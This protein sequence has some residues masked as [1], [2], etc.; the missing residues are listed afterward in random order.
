MGI[1]A[2]ADDTTG[3]LE[4]GAQ[5]ARS[6]V[7]AWISL[8]PVPLPFDTTGLVLDLFV[9]HL[10]ADLA[11]DR[12]R[13][14]AVQARDAGIPYLYLKTDS[15]LRGP[16]G[17]EFQALLE[18][19][20]DRAL[21]YAPAYPA[22]GRTVI[23]GVLYVDGQPLAETAFA[24]D[25]LEPAR[26]SSVLRL[27]QREC[28]APVQLVRTPEEL[29]TALAQRQGG[30]VL[31][32]DGR[33]DADLRAFAQVLTAHPDPYLV[34][35]PAGFVG[36]WTPL[37]PV[38]RNYVPPRLRA[39]RWLV[40]NG[41]LHPRSREQTA[42]SDL[43]RV[44]PGQGMPEDGNWALLETPAEACG[45]APDIARRLA[46]TA[47]RLVMQSGIEGLVVFGG[48][49]AR[50]ILEALHVRRVEACGELLP[51]IPVS[52]A[53]SS[54]LILVSKAGGFGPPDVLARIRQEAERWQ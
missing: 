51:G 30:R 43:P 13:D 19:Y 4:V 34:A 1:L 37:L 28:K 22:L 40:I 46:E 54:G 39:R 38:P 17:A 52:R 53:P 47:A 11:A 27:V 7:C 48:D 25:P 9:R 49:T 24:R 41:S 2:L 6:G 15:T 20:P 3:A 18:T 44:L 45:A 12:V 8:E 29:R 35:G 26:Q 14:A 16:I 32:C 50:A 31:V 10:P 42:C 33:D 21:V 36:H 23:E 5:L